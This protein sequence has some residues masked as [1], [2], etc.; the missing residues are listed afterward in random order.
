M[1]VTHTV[2]FQFKSDVDSSQVREAC[3][4]CDRFLALK[5]QCIHPTSNTP[6]I[7][8]LVGGKDNSPEGMQNGLT[9]GFVVIFNSTEDRDYYVKTDPAHQDFIGK[10][11]SLLEK[12]TVLDFTNGVY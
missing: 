4:I 6:Y 8:S 1:T 11:G 9:H 3:L 12:V 2:L 5:D 10:V 7:V